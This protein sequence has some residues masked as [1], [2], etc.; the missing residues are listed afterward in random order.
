MGIAAGTYDRRITISEQQRTQSTGSG[1][2][3]YSWVAVLT[4]VPA[5]VRYDS[6]N[7]NF[8][9]TQRVSAQIVTF[10]IRYSSIIKPGQQITFEGKIFNILYV[11][12]V[13]R[14]VSLSIRAE[15]KDNTLVVG[16]RPI[17]AA[18]PTITPNGN[19]L[20]GTT[21]SS[22]TGTWSGSAPIT[23]EY[24]WT[25]NGTPIAGATANTY[26]SVTADAGA[27][28]RCEVRATNEFGVS[29]YVASSNS[30]TAGIAPANT[31]APTLSPSGT[32]ATGT[33]ITAATGT[34]TGSAPITF[35][36]R[37]TRNGTP[38]TGAT[39]SS[40]IIQSA[41]DGTTIR[42][43]VK[44]TNA[45]A[46]SAYVTSSNSATGASGLDPDA[47]AF[48]TA[49]GITNATQQQAINTLVVDMK[50]Y[51]IWTKMK[52]IYPFVGGTAT[53]HKYNLKDP[54]DLDAAF[55]L[56][57]N[58]GWTHSSTGSTPN[59]TNGYADTFFNVNTN[60]SINSAH[61]S[62]YNRNN[63]LSGVQVDGASNLSTFLQ[64]NYTGAN[65]VIGELSSIAIYTQTDTRGLFT[66]T[67]TASN[68]LKVFKNSSSVANDTNTVSTLPSLNLFLGARNDN[69][70]SV[71]YNSYECAFAS[72]G[73]G[74]TDTESANL[75][76]AVQAFQT[77][78][79][80]NV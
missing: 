52:A 18:A 24:R 50:G 68:S 1:Q 48:I 39:N 75:Y 22:N 14:R 15:Q 55:R 3:N 76:T 30:S 74:L 33:L 49:A 42:V 78:L 79:G 71:F 65:G 8:E 29:A 43:E 38:I 31:V 59:G 37:W 73:N 72:I 23:F 58:G 69:G 77:T 51:G 21:Y 57:F 2:L 7:Q 16:D 60:L 47:Q 34:W 11:A 53:A 80:R 12:E 70:L 20:V 54:R 56:V 19:Q 10:E 5:R 44:A 45:F 28:L 17:N 9:A 36:Y 61:F 32:Q 25:R 46:A 13:G 4:N 27:I 63:N 62:K 6:G 41:D 67:R 35:E 66:V 40:Y 26:T 64:Q